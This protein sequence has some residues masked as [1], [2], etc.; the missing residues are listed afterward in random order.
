[1]TPKGQGHDPDIFDAEYLNN[2]VRYMV[3][4]YWLQIGNNTLGIQWSRDR[5]DLIGHVTWKAKV[6]TPIPLKLNISKTVQDKRSVQIDPYRK[7]HIAN[8]MVTWQMTSRDP[9]GQGRDP[10]IFEAEY[11]DNRE[12]YMVDSYLTTNRKPH[13]AN[14]VITWLMTSRDLNGQSR[15]PNTFEA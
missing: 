15:D 9:K 1:V 14:P 6:V 8:P 2:R 3:G 10:D 11:L 12:R 4:S 7:P 13:I 5:R